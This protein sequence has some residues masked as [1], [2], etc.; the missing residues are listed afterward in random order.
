M[1]YPSSARNEP[2]ELCGGQRFETVG[3]RDRCGGPLETV[4]C[5]RCGLVSHARIPTE[6]ELARYYRQAYR[7]AYKGEETPSARRVVRAWSN[8]RRLQRRLEGCLRPGS[9]AVDAGCRL[10]NVNDAF[11]VSAPDLGALEL[12]RPAPIYGPRHQP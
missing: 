12:G 2:C 7:T 6:E 8:G 5:R 1:R 4:V 11:A 3:A 10:P 9:R